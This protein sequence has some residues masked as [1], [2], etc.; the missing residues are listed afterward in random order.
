MT[1]KSSKSKMTD[2]GALSYG[3][4]KT[5]LGKILVAT[6]DKGVVSILID[7]S[8]AKLLTSHSSLARHYTCHGQ[9]RLAGVTRHFATPR[10]EPHREERTRSAGTVRNEFRCEPHANIEEPKTAQVILNNPTWSLPQPVYHRVVRDPPISDRLAKSAGRPE[11]A[12][13]GGSIPSLAI[14]FHVRPGH[15]GN[16]MYL[17]HR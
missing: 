16:R 9:R 2:Q 15:M 3:F 1:K 13:V 8:N 17:R 12:G 4:G 14:S 7:G 5:T 10:R 6:S 11:K